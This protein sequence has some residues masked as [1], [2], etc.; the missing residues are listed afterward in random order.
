MQQIAAQQG[1]IILP[2]HIECVNVKVN[3]LS[4][5]NVMHVRYKI[6]CLEV[7]CAQKTKHSGLL[8]AHV[9]RLRH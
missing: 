3:V 7:T 5:V 8:G 6:H 9:G 2:F 4:E 1:E